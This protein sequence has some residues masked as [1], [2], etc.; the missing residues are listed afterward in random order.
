MIL[1]FKLGTEENPGIIFRTIQDLFQNHSTE[2]TISFLEVYNETIKDLLTP[3]S[4]TLDLREDENKVAISGLTHHTPRDYA[5]IMEMLIKGNDN[6]T[7]AS[8]EANAVSSRSHAVVQIHV[9]QRNEDV[10]C[11]ATLSIIDLAGKL[12]IFVMWLDFN[13]TTVLLGSERA[14]ATKNQG[15][16]MVEGAN[17]NRYQK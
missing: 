9:K 15:D 2:L 14:S 1:T 8:T 10:N 3:S 12:P 7:K 6:R 16:R 11:F 17:I 5:H 4:K 13:Y